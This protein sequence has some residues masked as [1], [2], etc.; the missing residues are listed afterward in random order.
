MFVFALL[1]LL[2]IL[3]TRLWVKKGAGFVAGPG[4]HLRLLEHLPLG[5]GKGLFLVKVVDKVIL[6]AVSNQDIIVLRE[7]PLTSELDSEPVATGAARISHWLARVSPK[8][9]QEQVEKQAASESDDQHRPDF[10]QELLDRL[11][12]LKEPHR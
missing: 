11:R 5:A 4:K 8:R 3:A 7:F 12:K 10:A 1:I 9:L 6:L 2:S